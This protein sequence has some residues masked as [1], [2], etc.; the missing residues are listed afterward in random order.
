MEQDDTIGRR[1]RLLIGRSAPDPYL[2]GTR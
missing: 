1:A 2:W